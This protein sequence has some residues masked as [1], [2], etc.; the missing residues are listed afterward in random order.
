MNKQ[1]LCPPDF[2]AKAELQTVSLQ[3][4]DVQLFVP[5][6]HAVE[7]AYRRGEISFPYWSK[8]W[9]AAI[10]MSEYLML[11]PELLTNKTVLELGAGLGLPSLVASRYASSVICTDHAPEAIDF[12]RLSAE[13]NGLTNFHAAVLDW[14]DLP[15]EIQPDVVLLS[16]IN[17][18][19]EAF[20]ALKKLV[21]R[22]LAKGST[23]L[24]TTPQRL[25][26]KPI[27]EQLL[28]FSI[29]Q[30]EI[31]TLIE[32]TVNPISLLIMADE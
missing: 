23:I 10:A 13:K 3:G 12:A 16:D 5:N 11:H 9:P 1:K 20:A 26:A 27:I 18:E 15:E 2:T 6:P 30:Q 19:P 4:S 25:M 21:Q 31:Q 8:I 32:G 7:E 28:P 24:L 17:Y 14:N 22:F 29:H